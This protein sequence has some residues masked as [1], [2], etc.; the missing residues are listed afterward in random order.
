M[1]DNVDLQHLVD[2]IPSNIVVALTK[3]LSDDDRDESIPIDT[4]TMA[5]LAGAIGK[6]VSTDVYEDADIL[7]LMYKDPKTLANLDTA[8]YIQ[9]RNPVVT[10][11]LTVL[12]S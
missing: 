5:T 12:V 1:T 10:E 3:Y 6:A 7:S 9:K 8:E 2:C 11:R 4:V